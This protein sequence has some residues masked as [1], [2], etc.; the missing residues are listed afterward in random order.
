MNVKYDH[1]F[2]V[3]QANNQQKTLYNGKKSKT[4]Q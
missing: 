4:L 1:K 2:G 3:M